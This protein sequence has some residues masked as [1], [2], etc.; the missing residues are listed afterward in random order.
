MKFTEYFIRHKVSS[1]ILNMM[2]LIIGFLCLKNISIREYPDVQIP[3][4]SV[5]TTYPSASASVVESGVT[6]PLEDSISGVSGIKYLTSESKQNISQIIIVFEDGTNIDKAMIDLQN[7]VS[8]SQSK[9]PK[10]IDP[11][12]ISKGAGNGGPPFF[13]ITISSDEMNFGELT[14][15]A[16]RYIKNNFRSV[17][18]VAGVNVWSP[19]YTMRVTIDPKKLYAYGVNITDIINGLRKYNVSLP[20][21]KFQNDIPTTLDLD[22]KSPEEFANTAITSKN[23]RVIYLKDI[24]TT[25]LDTDG[26]MFRIHI[27]GKTGVV[28]GIEKNG[29][30][31]PL[32]V[33]ASLRKKMEDIKDGLPDHLKMSV[34]I[35]SSQ[36]ISSSLSN[37]YDSIFEAIILVLI[38]VYIFLRNFRATLIPLITI[39]FSL[40][41]AIAIM[42]AFGMSINILT[43]LAMVMAIG[44]VVDDAIIMLENI[45]R[46]IEEGMK[47]FDAAIKGASEIG[48]AIVAMTLTLA[49]VYEP[50]FFLKGLVADLFIE[51][52]VALAGSVLISGI[53]ALTLSPMMC[54]VILKN[55]NTDKESSTHRF[56]QKL[57]KKYASMLHNVIS[58]P[59]LIIGVMIG[60]MLISYVFAKLMPQEIVPK[61][62]RGLVGIFL[63]PVPGENMDDME[64]HASDMEKIITS[65]PEGRESLTFIGPWGAQAVVPLKDFKDRSRHQNKIVESLNAIASQMPSIDAHPWGWESGLPGMDGAMG[66]MSLKLVVS[67]AGDYEELSKYAQ[68]LTNKM[69]GLGKFMYVMHDVKFDTEGFD[70]VLDKNKMANLNIDA[71]TVSDSINTFFSGNKNLSFK[72]DDVL[73]GITIDSTTSPWSLDEIYITAPSNLRISIGSFAKL[74]KT[75]SMAKLPHYN[76]M[77]AATVTGV[78]LPFISMESLMPIVM[79]LSDETFPTHFKKEWTGAAQAS[80]EAS[81]TALMMFLMAIVFIYSILAVQFDNFLDPFIIMLTVPLACGGALFTAW[82]FGQSMNIYTQIGIITLVGLITKHGILIVEFANKTLSTVTAAELTVT[83]A[84]AGVQNLYNL[85]SREGGNDNKAAIESAV[86]DAAIIRLRPIL[87]TTGAMILGS[88][89]LV[90][91]SGAGS[92][93]RTAIGIVLV[94][95]L[96]FGTFFTLFVLPKIYCWVKGFEKSKRKFRL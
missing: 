39:P 12:E 17:S 66:G 59:K 73:Y 76:Q 64:A 84:K 55:S 27:N 57:D 36:F 72:K 41:G 92:E 78:A 30:A 70:I 13:A 91:S 48:F 58:M 51:F 21:G 26:S 43:L 80:T 71:L 85:D 4:L 19:Q 31:N 83:P 94:G 22:L 33:A 86:T 3:M 61:E 63:A 1:I 25:I 88:V 74:N 44:L 46:H 75:I 37:I 14:H 62:D 20:V 87:M 42:Q 52:A 54:S 53:V 69:N 45:T 35:D 8:R 56:L 24:A 7:A 67:S 38:I 82:L 49:S 79:K 9:L 68:K 23:G 29:D 47:P 11:P 96:G 93:A 5:K 6:G 89:P 95:G 18:G 15:Y 34:S 60:S 40:I 90:L 81:G 16:T 32:D 65:I 50:I 2:I 28:I 10:D 77:R